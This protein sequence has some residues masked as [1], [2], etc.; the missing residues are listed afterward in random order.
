MVRKVSWG[1]FLGVVLVLGLSV[2]GFAK[3]GVDP[4]RKVVQIVG[5][6]AASGKYGDYGLGDKRGQEIA[7]DEIN[8]AG[9]IQ[10]GPLSGYRLK[11]E[12]FDDRGDPK[13]SANIA[14]RISAGD[15]LVAIGPTISSCA[16]AATP[17]F[18][19]NRVP[20]IITYSNANTITEQGFDNVIRLTYTTK[21]IARYIAEQVKNQFGKNSVAIISENQDYGQQLVKYFKEAADSLGISVTSESVITPGQDLDFK[22]VLLKAMEKDPQFLV[23][24]VTYNEGGMIVRQTRQLGWKVPIYVP[25]AMTE[26]KFYELAGDVSNVYIQ[27]SPTIDMSRPAAKILKEEWEKRYGGVPPLSAIYGYDAV[28]VAVKVMEA[29]A[30]DR[31]SFIK[32][33]RT[34]KHEGVANPLYTFDDKGDSQ[35]PPFVT[36]P[37]NEYYEKNIKG[38]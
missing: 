7:V 14:K 5:Y 36:M 24:F 29:G 28:K 1:V 30:T 35:A 2:W 4:D 3:D 26:P 12:F 38:K 18:Y 9:G 37:C 32:L 23:L 11:L 6:D 10:Q 34:V 15:Y 22:S 8:A 27:L 33:M 16:L 19:R 13:E 25:D 21:S 31:E 20:N 17:V